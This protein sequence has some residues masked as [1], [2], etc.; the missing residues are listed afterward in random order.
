VTLLAFAIGVVAGTTIGLALGAKWRNDL[1][2]KLRISEARLDAYNLNALATDHD[3]AGVATPKPTFYDVDVD[4]PY[5][6]TPSVRTYSVPLHVTEI[7]RP[8]PG[9][10]AEDTLC[11]W[12][13]DTPIDVLDDDSQWCS[14]CEEFIDH[15]TAD[16]E[17]SDVRAL[18]HGRLD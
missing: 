11:H 13:C 4:E 16:D 1:R 3:V 5:A 9:A 6:P 8:I 10:R 15:D 17:E 12:R 2:E 7:E 18:P 14:T